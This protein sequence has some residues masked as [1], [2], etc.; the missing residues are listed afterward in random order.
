MHQ[1]NK[2]CFSICLLLD[3]NNHPSLPLPL[4]CHKI[5]PLSLHGQVFRNILR[6]QCIQ[7]RNNLSPIYFCDIHSIFCIQIFL[8]T[9]IHLLLELVCISLAV[10]HFSTCNN[11]P[12]YRVSTPLLDIVNHTGFIRVLPLFQK[13]VNP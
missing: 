13:T 6:W 2:Y 11:T 10:H 8:P 9:I 7:L 5:I 12:S 4:S 3:F 1:P